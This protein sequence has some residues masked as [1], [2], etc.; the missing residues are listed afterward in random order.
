MANQVRNL[1]MI[2]GTGA[3]FAAGHI[4]LNGT[5]ATMTEISSPQFFAS[6]ITLIRVGA[7]RYQVTLR[8][9]RGPNNFVIPTATVGS[10]S[11]A[12]LGTG[13]VPGLA[14]AISLNSYTSNTDTYS[15]TVTVHSAGTIT[16][17]DVYWQAY[18]F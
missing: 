9:F 8:N 14:T 5:T 13:I 1:G 4:A 3:L 7:G 12:A 10:S 11:T 18:A 2:E 6:D 15:F 17:A 16:D